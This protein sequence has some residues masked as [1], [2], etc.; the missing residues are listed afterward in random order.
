MHNIVYQTF[1]HVYLK[2]YVSF[3]YYFIPNYVFCTKNYNVVLD[4]IF[5]L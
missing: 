3:V 2:K 1:K 5:K 4:Y